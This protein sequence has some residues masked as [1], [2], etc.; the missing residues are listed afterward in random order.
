MAIDA[1][2][3]PAGETRG[4][5]LLPGVLAEVATGRP[6]SREHHQAG[7]QEGS[8]GLRRLLRE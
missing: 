8:W 1:P 3:L 6:G 4:R 5:Q 7:Q 2:H